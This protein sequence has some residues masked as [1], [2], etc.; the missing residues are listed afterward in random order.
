MTLLR[1]LTG[2][3]LWLLLGGMVAFALGAWFPRATGTTDSTFRDYWIAVGD[4]YRGKRRVLSG[5]VAVHLHHEARLAQDPERLA[6]NLQVA[7][8]Q[9]EGLVTSL[10]GLHRQPLTPAVRRYAEACG[11]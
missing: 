10:D 3:T 7:G 6:K 9:V 4:K 11:E 5:E 8:H 2:R 1:H